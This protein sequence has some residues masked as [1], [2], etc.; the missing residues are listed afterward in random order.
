MQLNPEDLKPVDRSYAEHTTWWQGNTAFGTGTKSLSARA[1]AEEET[2]AG[3]EYVLQSGIMPNSLPAMK[4]IGNDTV[5]VFQAN[6]AR[7][8]ILDSAVLMY[9][10]YRSGIWSEPVPVWDNGTCD[11]YADLQVINN[12]L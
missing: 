9:S 6:D 7:R 2:A 3:T 1:G 12:D 11:M 10:V 5:M 4:K 8:N